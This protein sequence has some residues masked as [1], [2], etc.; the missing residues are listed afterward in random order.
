MPLHRGLTAVDLTSGSVVW[1]HPDVRFL[2]V[3]SGAVFVA[4]GGYE[5][6]AVERMGLETGAVMGGEEPEGSSAGGLRR[7]DLPIELPR[8][9]RESEVKDPVL[10]AG[11]RGAIPRTA[12]P[13]SVVLVQGEGY[14]VLA[15]SEPRARDSVEGDGFR[16]SLVV[17][18]SPRWGRVYSGVV[19][20][21]ASA[22]TQ[23]PFFCQEGW[24]YFVQEHTTL[25]AVPLR[26]T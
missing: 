3:E 22:V 18:G 24:L 21:T 1:T 9:F 6:E 10:L 13:E 23:E 11:I 15:F 8:P 19:Q 2:R 4:K 5:G 26:I 14:C 12:N 16:S 25:V 17:L 7:A 20:R